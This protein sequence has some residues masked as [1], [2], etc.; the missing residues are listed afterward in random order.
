MVFSTRLVLGLTRITLFSAGHVSQSAVSPNV[1]FPQ[2]D[3]SRNSPTTMFWS[4]SMRESVVLS[5]LR[6]QTLSELAAMLPLRSDA[7]EGIVAVTFRLR[8]SSRRTL[9]F[10]QSGTQ[11]LLNA[12]AI[13]PHGFATSFTGSPALLA[14][15]SILSRW[16]LPG[17][18]SD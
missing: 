8:E 3:V 9:P 16:S 17:A 1:M 15:T 10:P 6:I 2:S 18:Y 5:S 13:P 14:R 4:G 12:N 7:P 11:R